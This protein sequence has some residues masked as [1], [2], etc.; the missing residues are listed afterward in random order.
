M[1]GADCTRGCRNCGKSFVRAGKGLP[2][3]YC[4][5]SCRDEKRLE[6]DRRRPPKRCS[7]QCTVSG[8]DSLEQAKGFCSK[9]YYRF[10]R[11][12]DTLF[13]LRG[14]RVQKP[15][16]WCG[17]TMELKPAIAKEQRY[18]C[19]S[20]GLKARALR[21]GK[22]GRIKLVSCRGCGAQ[23]PRMVRAC[24]DSG[25]YCSRECYSR[26][27]TRLA[28]EKEALRRIAANWRTLD[29]YSDLVLSEV[30]ALRRIAEWKPGRTRTVRPCCR[31]GMKAAGI[32]EMRRYCRPCKETAKR[33]SAAKVRASE[34]GRARRRAD[35][36]MRRAAERGAHADRIDPIRVFG[37]DGWRCHLCG[38]KTPHRLR[39]SY[40]PNAPEL[41]HVIPL[42]LGG[43]HTWGNVRCACRACNGKKGA[44]PLG[45]L[46]MNIAA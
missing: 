36:A 3:Q 7:R 29:G 44:R 18:C 42:A 10:R 40:E 21:E 27:K 23:A 20:C 17:V 19:R 33:E 6:K 30:G 26:W 37:R 16:A 28:L 11:H 8:C 39:G 34:S 4:S 24:K 38:C 46:G 9:H 31:C 5:V 32:G 1:A 43:T 41:D 14:Y 22:T 35:K 12:G 45:Q 2:T 13:T 15:C 25:E